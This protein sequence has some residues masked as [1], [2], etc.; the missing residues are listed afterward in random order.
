MGGKEKDDRGQETEEI[1][2]VREGKRGVG[3]R[4]REEKK[5]RKKGG[6]ETGMRREEKE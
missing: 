3:E 4:E 2:W 6:D 5:R 1:C